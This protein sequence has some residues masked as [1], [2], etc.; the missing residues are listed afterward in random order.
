VYSVIRIFEPCFGFESPGHSFTRVMACFEFRIC[1]PALI[2]VPAVV[3][4]WSAPGA[5]F[6]AAVCACAVACFVAAG[7]PAAVAAAC[8]HGNS[9]APRLWRNNI[10]SPDPCPAPRSA[11]R[12]F[13]QRR[14]SN[15]CLW[16]LYNSAAPLP[17]KNNIAGLSPSLVPRS[18]ESLFRQHKPN[19]ICPRNSAAPFFAKDNTGRLVPWLAIQGAE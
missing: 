4:T 1:P 9:A 6:A 18:V 13:R 19:K 5:S 7:Y 8:R 10:A 12:L 16:S 2:S 14:P 11:G 17:S 15:A 3:K